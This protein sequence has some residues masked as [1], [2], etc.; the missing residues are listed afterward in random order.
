MR[1]PKPTATWRFDI[2]YPRH[3][4][5]MK[6]KAN[7]AS[8]NYRFWQLNS[9]LLRLNSSLWQL[10]SSLWQLN[11]SLWQLNSSYWQLN[12][13]ILGRKQKANNHKLWHIH[14]YT[15]VCTHQQTATRTNAVTCT[16]THAHTHIL[17]PWHSLHYTYTHVQSKNTYLFVCT[18]GDFKK[19]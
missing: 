5:Q 4:Q 17:S 13:H 1:N 8:G 15:L 10:N 2:S 6:Q 12:L 18:V 14:W 19:Y 11:S 9:L 3:H 7:T 16:C